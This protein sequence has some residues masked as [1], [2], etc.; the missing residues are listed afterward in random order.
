M[1]F[2][3]HIC[4]IAACLITKFIKYFKAEKLMMA[5]TSFPKFEFSLESKILSLV[6]KC[7]ALLNMRCSPLFIFLKVCQILKSE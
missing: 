6:T 7:V 1:Y 3:N 2:K 4:Y 5:D